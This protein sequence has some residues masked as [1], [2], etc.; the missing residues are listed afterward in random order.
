MN[1]HKPYSQ[2]INQ[3]QNQQGVTMIEAMVSILLFAIGALGLVALQYSSIVGSG[4]NQQRTIAI[5][6][7]QELA[8]RI[9]SNPS[10]IDTYKS[11][12]NNSTLDSIG[13]DSDTKVF[14]C[15]DYSTT[16]RCSDYIST[17]GTSVTNGAEC[18]DTK[19][20]DFD[21]WDV[22]CEQNTGGAVVGSSGSPAA[23][24]SAAITRLELALMDH[25]DGSG[26]SVIYMEWLSR[27]GENTKGEDAVKNIST[28]LCGSTKNIDSRLDVYC[29]RFRP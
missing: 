23:D 6:K 13:V 22:F 7:A 1:M 16:D 29:L 20:V 25:S 27:E 4:D 12:I 15:S 18:S 11:K 9:K 17:T 14:K 26:D 28:E 5:W 8:N 24:G 19:K 21:I 3:R 2:Q 10:E